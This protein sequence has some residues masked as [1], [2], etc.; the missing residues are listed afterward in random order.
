MQSLKSLLSN[1]WRVKSMYIIFLVV[2]FLADL[3]THSKTVWFYMWVA[4]LSPGQLPSTVQVFPFSQAQCQL[5]SAH[6]YSSPCGN[7]G[8]HYS[9]T[10]I[11]T[12]PTYR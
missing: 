8:S 3:A 9:N 1:Q 6:F 5:A 7:V 10:V 2:I 11:V 4:K 12:K